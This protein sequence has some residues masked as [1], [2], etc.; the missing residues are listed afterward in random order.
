MSF[1]PR[2]LR[3]VRD[4]SRPA[5]STTRETLQTKEQIVQKKGFTDIMMG[6][7]LNE[8]RKLRKEFDKHEEGLSM[9]QVR[10]GSLDNDQQLHDKVIQFLRAMRKC[11]SGWD[12]TEEELIGVL[13]DMFRE[14]DINGDQS[15]EWDVCDNSFFQL[16]VCYSLRY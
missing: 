6:L 2:Q 1:T 3:T 11:L 4:P 8:M 7:G 14:I 10:T 15:M 12:G 13:V 9:H 16:Y 5:T